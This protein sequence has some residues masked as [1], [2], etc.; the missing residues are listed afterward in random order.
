M[1]AGKTLCVNDL[2]F[3]GDIADL[4]SADWSR[5][6]LCTEWSNHE[7]LAHLVIGR[8]APLCTVTTGVIR[9]R[10]FD[11]EN[12]R[13]ARALAAQRTPGELIS[14]YHRFTEQPVGVG[15]LFPRS[16]LLGDHVVHELDILFA[17]G[18]DSQVPTDIL[19]KVLNTQVRLPNPFVPAYFTARGLRLHAT[20]ADWHHGTSGPAV[21]G[22]AA[23]LASVLA[24]RP[25]ILAH[26]RGHGVTLLAQRLALTTR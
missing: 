20:D 8:S 1:S 11:R 19:V 16:L 21:E 26:L 9:Q 4:T 25:R 22:T 2:R 7:V 10:S 23:A 14:D 13:A 18:R 17:L 12:T 15:K 3:L 24:G 6:S 5:P